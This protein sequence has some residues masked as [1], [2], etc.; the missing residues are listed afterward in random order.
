MMNLRSLVE[1]SADADL[2]REMIGFAAEKLME[3]EVDAKTGA[4]Y[5]EKNALQLAQRSGYRGP[6][7]SSCVSPNSGRAVIFRAF[8][9][10]AAWPIRL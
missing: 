1:K 10:R 7:L 5:G 4:P 8:W 2:L 6:E 3:L 9:S